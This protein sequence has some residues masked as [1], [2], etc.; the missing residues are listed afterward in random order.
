M[1]SLRTVTECGSCSIPLPSLW[2]EVA[3]RMS[4]RALRPNAELGNV[5]EF[6]AI[7]LTEIAPRTPSE[8]WGLR[9]EDVLQGIAKFN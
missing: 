7:S 5:R 8:R 9:E 2:I 4:R 1:L 6:S 3:E